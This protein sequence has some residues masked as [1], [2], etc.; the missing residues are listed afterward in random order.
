LLLAITVQLLY[1]GGKEWIPALNKA[2]L[3]HSFIFLMLGFFVFL[4]FS[5][6]II[7]AEERAEI[8]HIMR[9]PSRIISQFKN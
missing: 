6:K 1:L 7:T 5:T 8:F 9:S 2:Y 3:S 4:L